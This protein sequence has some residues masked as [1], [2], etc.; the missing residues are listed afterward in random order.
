[1]SKTALKRLKNRKK[2]NITVTQLNTQYAVQFQ[3]R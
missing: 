2:E 1:M 3:A